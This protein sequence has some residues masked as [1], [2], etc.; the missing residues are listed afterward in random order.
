MR[1]T[2]FKRLPQLAI[3][4]GATCFV[5]ALAF[6][7]NI[8]AA[9]NVANGSQCQTS[10]P[11]YWEIGGVSGAPIVS[12][13]VGG[14]TYSRTT[15]VDLA[16][17]SKW[18]FST[19]V[20][21][22]YNGPPPGTLGQEVVDALNMKRGHTNMID[23]WCLGTPTVWDC[24]TIFDND[25]QNPAHV[26][27][28]YYNSG[29]AQMAAV[30][31]FHLNLSGKT[32]ATLLVE[33]NSYLG[34]G[35]SFAYS[36]PAMSSGM[37]SNSADYA[38]FLQKIMNGTYVMSN[39]LNYQPV[40]IYP[41]DSGI[42][43]C[44]PFGTVNSH[45]SLNHLIEDDGGGTFTAF[46]PNT[47]IAAGDGAYSDPGAYG[48]YPW[49]SANKQYYGIVSTQGAVGNYQNTVPCGREIRKAFIGP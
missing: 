48:Y 15:V 36:A 22:R 35:S 33:I 2:Q 19:Y 25:V 42:T 13:Q 38:T 10:R 29:H 26:G 3:A 1:K 31:P 28:F 47:T 32:N 4:A 34:L 12:G 41:C 11:F 49:I 17:S 30:S 39:Y 9:T 24:G 20:L 40:L 7:Y 43:G 44:T 18:I 27:H 21:Q 46:T 5:P 6:A 8:V 37:R 23:L 14:T 45:Y 16:S